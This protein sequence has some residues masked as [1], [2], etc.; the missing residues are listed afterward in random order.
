MGTLH[1]IGL[2]QKLMKAGHSVTIGSSKAH[3]K[4]ITSFYI[5]YECIDETPDTDL[6]NNVIEKKGLS[7]VKEGIRLLFYGMFQSHSAILK[8]VPQ[9]DCIIG[10][11]WLGE[12]EAE[13]CGIQFIRVGISPN[14]AEKVK[15][16]AKKFGQKIMI[17]IE[18]YA[19]T[20][21]ILKPYNEFREKVNA[22][23]I[24]LSDINKKPLFIPISKVL[25]DSMDLWNDTTYQ[26]S[27]WYTDNSGYKPPEELMKLL[28]NGKKSILINFG[29]MTGWISNNDKLERMLT[30]VSEKRDVN[31]IVIGKNIVQ[32][33]MNRRLFQ[34]E[35]IPLQ[36][37]LDK[38]DV[39]FHHCGLGTTSEILRNGCPS[40]PVPFVIDQFDWAKRLIRTGAAA[41]ILPYKDISVKTIINRLDVVFGNELYKN[42]ALKIKEIV[43]AEIKEDRT[44][45]I[46]EKIIKG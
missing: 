18:S 19:V 37:I 26:S 39:C 4:L 44:A 3:E 14:V 35:E 38:V 8:L 16:K 40:V 6:I 1:Y 21:L 45:D 27:Y 33:N 13:Q 29:S 20:Q 32:D 42:N 17:A 41:R 31:I 36:F 28:Q 43:L 12:T 15:S 9:F 7:A 23:L 2:A 25:I 46:V 24:S 11:G 30:E 34:I 10:H 5:G 22:P